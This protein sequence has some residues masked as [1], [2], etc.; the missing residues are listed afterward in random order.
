MLY[1]QCIKSIHSSL[2]M[3]QA[4]LTKSIHQGERFQ[5]LATSIDP[6]LNTK[7][8]LHLTIQ[9]NSPPSSH[10]RAGRTVIKRF[11]VAFKSKHPAQEVSSWLIIMVWGEWTVKLKRPGT[12]T[13]EMILV[14]M[15]LTLNDMRQT[16]MIR[17]NRMPM[18]N[19]AYEHTNLFTVSAKLFV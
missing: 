2:G 16:Y 9:P 8:S 18:Q 4:I 12:H 15:V 5:P 14:S 1:F 3:D 6:E 7:S 17:M 10:P 11:E 13:T 19:L